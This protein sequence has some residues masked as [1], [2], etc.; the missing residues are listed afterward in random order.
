MGFDVADLLENLFG[1]GPAAAAAALDPAP[2]SEA[3]PGLPEAVPFDALPLPGPACAACGSLSQ[4]QDILGR[5]RCGVCEA[6]ALDTALRL[7]ERA[8]RLRKQAQ[9]RKG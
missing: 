2:V 7:A 4:W 8:A 9:P 5:R 1:N 3:V 6:E